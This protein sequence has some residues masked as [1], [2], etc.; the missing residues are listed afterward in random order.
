MVRIFVRGDE[1]VAYGAVLG[2]M[3]RIRPPGSNAWRSSRS[4]P[5]RNEHS[6]REGAP[7]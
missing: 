1:A 7:D 4:F 5:I 3:G 2:V 6:R